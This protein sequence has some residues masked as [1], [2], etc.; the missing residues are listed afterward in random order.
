MVISHE[1]GSTEWPSQHNKSGISL[2]LVISR[3]FI[4]STFILPEAVMI[5]FLLR[6]G[7]H[8]LLRIYDFTICL[9]LNES[10]LIWHTDFFSVI[11][12]S[13]SFSSRRPLHPNEMLDPK[14]CLQPFYYYHYYHHY[15]HYFN[16]MHRH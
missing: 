15:Y 6:H 3:K 5:L 10:I 1:C 12:F 13:F 9:Q 14:Y 11:F 16:F 2:L 4:Y 8:L 7:G